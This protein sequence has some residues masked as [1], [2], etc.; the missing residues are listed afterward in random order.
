VNDITITA[1]PVISLKEAARPVA[2]PAVAVP[3]SAEATIVT[4]APVAPV[5]AV[6][7]QVLLGALLAAATA[8][9]LAAWAF[10]P[11][12]AGYVVAAVLAVLVCV[13]IAS[14]R[15]RR[16]LVSAGI[17]P[18]ALMVMMVLPALDRF[19]QALVFYALLLVLATVYHFM[20]L[21][22]DDSPPAEPAAQPRFPYA[23]MIQ[24]GII[25]GEI[26]GFLSFVVLPHALPVARGAV[27]LLFPAAL[28]FAITEERLFRGLVQRQAAE[29]MH[30]V[31][32]ALLSAVMF[33]SLSLGLGSATAF[34]MA[35]ILG[36]ALAAMYFN[37]R[38][39]VVTTTLNFTSKLPF[40]ILVAL[41]PH[42]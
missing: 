27:G 42:H 33:A 35:L 7:W 18:L 22:T 16:L 10:W 19:V 8:L 14:D 5:L 20:F 28:L 21:F 1:N 13:A 11:A 4:A 31:G 36:L 34:G 17:V 30:P 29:I 15:L 23:L 40:I 26:L 9:P 25:V 2:A 32:A 3:E 24:G 38:N 39:V 41:L 12:A 6:G 37:T